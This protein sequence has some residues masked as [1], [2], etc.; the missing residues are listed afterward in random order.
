M[1][2][3]RIC[4]L[5]LASSI[6]LP[7][8]TP[9]AQ[10]QPEC[11]FELLPAGEPA[12]GDFHWF[13]RW[14]L[15]EEG[16]PWLNFARDGEGYLLRFPA[17]ADFFLSG[18]GADIRCRPLP[19]VPEV[20][21]RHLL[22]DQVIPLALSRRDRIVLHASAVLTPRGVIAFYGR[23]GLGKSTLA[24]SLARQ[25]HASVSDDCLV[26]R[27]EG[28][29]WMALPAYP[30]VRLWPS[31]AG[32]LLEEE[33]EGK[34]VAHYTAKRRISD[35]GILPFAASPARVSSLFCLAGDTSRVGIER[36]PAARAIVSLVESAFNL[37]IADGGLA[38]S[39]FEA[40]GQLAEELPAYT[41]HYPREFGALPAVTD[42]ILQ[43][44]EESRDA[45]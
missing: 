24:A 25:G 8:L 34:E 2:V 4:D 26:L 27:K 15:E 30:G 5:V 10:A 22:L 3:Y 41:I 40:V 38:R 19:G 11:R 36:I 32:E 28:P 39:Q 17:C 7:E 16:D 43:H 35:A 23:S 42:A 13:H 9:A 12:S 45:E 18:D 31:T 33:T 44:L 37:D 6:G 1:R 21:L 29:C 20:T 14:P